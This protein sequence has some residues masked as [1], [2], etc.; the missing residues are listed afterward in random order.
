MSIRS[1]QSNSSPILSGSPRFPKNPVPISLEQGHNPSGDDLPSSWDMSPRSRRLYQ[2]RM[3]M[4]RKRAKTIGGEADKTT[5]KLRPGSRRKFT[6]DRTKLAKSNIV[7]TES[8]IAVNFIM[9]K[10]Q[11][12][13]GGVGCISESN[14][15]G[16]SPCSMPAPRLPSQIARSDFHNCHVDAESIVAAGLHIFNHGKIGKLLRCATSKRKSKISHVSQAFYFW[17]RTTADE[18]RCIYQNRATLSAF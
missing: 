11:N 5:K 17:S 14:V 15:D 1:L 16:G 18:Q 9:S 12:C 7:G 3:Y 13:E 2:K 8:A 10:S 6:Q 4:R